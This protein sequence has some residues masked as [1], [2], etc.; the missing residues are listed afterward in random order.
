MIARQILAAAHKMLPLVA[1]Q[2][3]RANSDLGFEAE[4]I[5]GGKQCVSTK[6]ADVSKL[7]LNGLWQLG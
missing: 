1:R 3:K 4:F 6:E 2:K 5:A 7:C